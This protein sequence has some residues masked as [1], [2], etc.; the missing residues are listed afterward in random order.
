MNYVKPE[1]IKEYVEQ[2]PTGIAGM[3][4]EL[5]AMVNHFV[6]TAVYK[7]I[8]VCKS[9]VGNSD[10]NTG[11]LHCVSDIKERFGLE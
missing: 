4:E 3:S 9:R 7:C 6:N 10:Y 5:T 1:N 11:R 2:N 8:N